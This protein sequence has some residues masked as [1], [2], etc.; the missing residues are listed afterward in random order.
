MP[1]AQ[2]AVVSLDGQRSALHWTL[3]DDCDQARPGVMRATAARTA[4]V[5]VSREC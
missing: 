2:G 5:C 1:A 3:E 4:S